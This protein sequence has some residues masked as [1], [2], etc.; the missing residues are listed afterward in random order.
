MLKRPI[1]YSCSLRTTALVSNHGHESNNHNG[2]TL[3]RCT[4]KLHKLHD[5]VAADYCGSSDLQ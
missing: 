4:S 5:V 3:V 1:A 2:T